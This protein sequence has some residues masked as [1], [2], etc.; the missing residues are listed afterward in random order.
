MWEAG[1]VYQLSQFT[2]APR[3]Q[4]GDKG[5]T[6]GGATVKISGNLPR[7][8]DV[9]ELPVS[10][11]VRA[12]IMHGIDPDKA[13]RW[14]SRSEP[15]FWVLCEMV[16][17]G[18]DDDTMASVIM[19]RDFGISAS[20]LDKPRPEKYAARQIQRAREEAIDPWLRE[21]NDKHIVIGNDGGKCRVAEWVSQ[22]GREQLVFQTFEDFRNRYMNKSVM[23]AASAGATKP[24][25]VG[26][27]WLR[28]PMRR[29]FAGLVFQPGGPPLVGS[30]L[31]LWRG[32]SVEPVP[33]DWSLMRAHIPQVLAAGN[34]A[35]AHY[36]M[37]W[38]AWT[39]QNPDKQAEV[40]LV[41]RGGEG[42]GKGALGRAMRW[43]YGQHGLHI[44]NA[45]Q[46]AGR[47]N[48]HLRD[49]CLLFADEAV[50]PDDQN[51]RGTLKALITEPTLAI[52][53][54]GRDIVQSPN[55][56][57]V[58]MA[59]NED[60]V[61]SVSRDD[62]RF[63]V[64]DVSEEHKQD[65]PY[66]TALFSQLDHGGYGAM[67]HDLL[68]MQLDGWHPRDDIPKTEART[69]QKAASLKGFERVFL[70]FLREGEMPAQGS[71]GPGRL[72]VATNDLQR[73]ANDRS[74]C[75]DITWNQVSD[76]LRRFGFEKDD[77]ARPRGWVSPTLP[78]V[79]AA[80][81]SEVF[82][83]QWDDVAEWSSV[84]PVHHVD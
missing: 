48:A 75:K 44:N 7:I 26:E 23:V 52:E 50:R 68:A 19:D 18:C 53:G 51:A 77:R 82:A 56:L 31:N 21:L 13:N 47:F 24:Q 30:R 46:L 11:S 29:E 74:P 42:T 80:W 69:E 83:M 79:R 57:K 5:F 60:F 38:I 25:C 16:R 8:E 67:L 32:F 9:S 65:K 14:A 33:G 45:A 34:Q 71:R 6:G 2:A 22:D 73:Y 4:V 59:S 39:L 78:E 10:H 41:L 58:I 66:F 63:A 54:K 20:V 81:D 64:F 70:D 62:R 43:L 84:H 17:A 61:V 1:R 72:F 55:Y 12:V 76:V 49:V 15:L 36:I 40:A 3:V 27:W 28:H 37:R 35:H